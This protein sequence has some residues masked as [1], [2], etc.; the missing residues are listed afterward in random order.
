MGI[1]TNVAKTVIIAC[2]PCFALVGHSEEAYVIRITGERIS[3]QYRICQRVCCPNCNLDLAVGSLE[4]HR[5]GQN[6]VTRRDMKEPIHPHPHPH[7]HSLD[8]AGTYLISFL[9]R[10]CDVACLVG[11]CLGRV[12]SRSALWVNFV[13]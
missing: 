6:G 10:A 5:Q 7:P 2:R 9:W 13:H 3:F 8:E 1:C 12:T 11:G 4:E